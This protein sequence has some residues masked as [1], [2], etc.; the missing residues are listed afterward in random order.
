M[1]LKEI[2]DNTGILIRFDDIA[3]NMNWEI[4]DKCQTLLNKYNIKP[5]LGVIPKNEDMELLSYPKRDNFWKIVKNTSQSKF[6]DIIKER[7]NG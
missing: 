5:L 7:L 1:L 6:S 4:M 3:P 2:K